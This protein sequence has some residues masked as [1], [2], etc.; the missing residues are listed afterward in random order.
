M[1]GRTV[2]ARNSFSLQLLHSLLMYSAT[3]LF[4]IP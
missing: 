3:I 1:N 2:E 4:F